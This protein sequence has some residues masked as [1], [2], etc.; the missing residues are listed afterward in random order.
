[1]GP[2]RGDRDAPRVRQGPRRD[3]RRR[4]AARRRWRR[5]DREH[6]HAARRRA[7]DRHA[8]VRRPSAALRRP[9]ARHGRVMNGMAVSG[10]LPAG[11]TFFVFS[12]YMRALGAPRRAV[13]YKTAFVWT[14]DSVGVGEDGPTH[15]PIEHLAA[16][17]A[18]P[19]PRL[20][21]PADAN[22][23][24]AG[25]ARSTSTAPGRRRSSSPARSVPVLAGTAERA[26][27]GVPRGA[28]TLVDEAMRP[29]S[30]A[31]RH[32][33][34]GAAVRRARELLAAD[35]TGARSCRCRRGSCSP[36][37]TSRTAS[38]CCRLACRRW[39]SRRARSSA[40]TATPTTSSRST[41]SARRRP[42][43]PS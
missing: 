30:R 5:P 27:E 40:G 32:G 20:I 9:R 6:R 2:R 36:R 11:G 42:A 26:P 15:Q 18:M 3:R 29:G 14:H 23:V 21:R 13:Q 34:G 24:R 4:A 1:M 17:R 10:S 19:E 33:L 28:Y 31:H 7:G 22:E 16:L 38:R 8:R 37:R 39:R 43:R 12:D 25:M 35:G 41:T